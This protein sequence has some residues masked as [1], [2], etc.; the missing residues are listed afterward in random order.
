[1]VIQGTLPR[2]SNLE[3]YL[4]D[5]GIYCRQIDPPEGVAVEGE[6][7]TVGAGTATAVASEGMPLYMF[8]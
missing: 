4:G 1:M 5:S 3:V 8:S 7:A 6:E 2:P